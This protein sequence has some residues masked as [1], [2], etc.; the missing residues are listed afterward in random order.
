MSWVIGVDTGGTFTDA[1]AADETGRIVSAKTPSTPPDFADGFMVA[2]ED[3]SAEVGGGIGALLEDT[4][5]I[6]HGTTSTLN[7]LVT[8]DLAT[9]G[10]LTTRGHADSISIMNLEGRYAGLGAAQI[11]NMARTNK[12]PALVP[13]ISCVRSTSARTTRAAWWC[14]WTRRVPARQSGN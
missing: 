10:F 2:L 8:G 1:F 13:R 9:V 6:V 4:S 14:R 7:A 3:L 11:Q 12:P 5:Y